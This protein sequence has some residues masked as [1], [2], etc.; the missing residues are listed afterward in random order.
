MQTKYIVNLASAFIP[1]IVGF[2]WYNPKV[3]GALLKK[4]ERIPNEDV[5][6]GH[7][8]WVY[9]LTYIG[10]YYIAGALG[11]IVIHQRGLLSMLANQPDLHTAGTAL[12]T[13]VQGLLDQ[14]GTNFRTFKHGALHGFY[15][16]LYL[17]LPVLGII[18]LFEKKNWLYIFIHGAYWIVCLTLMGGVICAYMPMQ[19]PL[20]K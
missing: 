14:Y 3:F 20:V 15:T 10:S 16:G 6:Q 11:G 18:A 17:A 13:N 1:L 5:N 19:F 4:A 2:I 8:P 7:A 12:N 9:L